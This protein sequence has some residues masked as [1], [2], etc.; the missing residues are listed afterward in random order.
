MLLNE[1]YHNLSFWSL[2]KFTY[3]LPFLYTC[4]N[5][6]LLLEER[7]I[8]NK[9]DI[10]IAESHFFLASLTILPRHFYTRSRP[11]IRIWTI[12]C[13]RKKYDCFAVSVSKKCLIFWLCLLHKDGIVEACVPSSIRQKAVNFLFSGKIISLLIN[14][15][16]SVIAFCQSTQMQNVSFS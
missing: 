8:L 9:F 1:S 16:Q 3:K 7:V 15:T 4:F 5:L 6:S 12:A 10:C 2:C 13:I 14:Y 11:F